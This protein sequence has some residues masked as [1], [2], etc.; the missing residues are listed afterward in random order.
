MFMRMVCQL[1]HLPFYVPRQGSCSSRTTAQQAKKKWKRTRLAHVTD[2][3]LTSRPFSRFLR[4]IRS[5]SMGSED[6]SLIRLAPLFVSLS[7]CVCVCQVFKPSSRSFKSDVNINSNLH[8]ALKR[9][10]MNLSVQSFL[11]IRVSWLSPLF[12]YLMD[13][14]RMIRLISI[15][16]I[17]YLEQYP[18]FITLMNDWSISFLLNSFSGL[19]KWKRL[20]CIFNP[21]HWSGIWNTTIKDNPRVGFSFSSLS[22]FSSFLLSLLFVNP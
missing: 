18:W 19:H 2:S 15:D 7:L 13:S 20:N 14:D 16:E 10:T 5:K 1:K 3:G 12:L 22:L 11:P 6:H 21:R 9:M 8:R 4:L 17:L